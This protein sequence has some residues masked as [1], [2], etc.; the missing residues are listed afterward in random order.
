MLPSDV[1][2]ILA[3]L[4]YNIQRY[5]GR[6][7]WTIIV[8]LPAGLAAVGYDGKQRAEFCAGWHRSRREVDA[9]APHIQAELAA[10]VASAILTP[11]VDPPT[12]L[13]SVAW[14]RI[15]VTSDATPLT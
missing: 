15:I 14:T 9:L 7:G 6:K 4:V 12:C 1:P 11:G 10:K 8:H 13:T 5:S 3:T 2:V